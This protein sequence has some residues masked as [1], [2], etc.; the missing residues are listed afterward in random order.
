MFSHVLFPDWRDVVFRWFWFYKSCYYWLFHWLRQQHCRCLLL[1]VI[2]LTLTTSQRY[3]SLQTD[4]WNS[5]W[6]LLIVHQSGLSRP[7]L[8]FVVS[9]SFVLLCSFWWRQLIEHSLSRDLLIVVLHCGSEY[10]WLS[11]VANRLWPVGLGNQRSILPKARWIGSALACKKDS[12]HCYKTV[13]H[14]RMCCYFLLRN[15]CKLCAN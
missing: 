4:R 12:I 8:N 7:F 2:I 14:W 9:F 11:E 15:L 3:S 6:H 13:P 10:Q 5:A 1:L